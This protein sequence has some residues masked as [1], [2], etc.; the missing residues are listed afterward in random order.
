MLLLLSDNLN[1]FVSNYLVDINLFDID[2][3][4]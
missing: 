1:T 4:I 3:R 2:L